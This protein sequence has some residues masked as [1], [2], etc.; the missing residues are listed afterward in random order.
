MNNQT[1]LVIDFGGQYNQLIVRR[2][3]ALGVYAELVSNEITIEKIK[4]YSP[5][6]IVFTGGPCS[7]SAAGAPT[8]DA[9]IFSLG[10]PFSAFATGCNSPPN[11]SA[12]KSEKRLFANTADAK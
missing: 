4:E 10:I 8:V 2:V 12:A 6:G 1:V 5:V 11:Y 9:R 3:R 7:V